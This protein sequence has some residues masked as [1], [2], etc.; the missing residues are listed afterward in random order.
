ML[1]LV[2][3]PVCVRSNT[4]LELAL[5]LLEA[6]LKCASVYLNELSTR[7]LVRGAA[8]TNTYMHGHC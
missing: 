3:Q 7:L 6:E 2:G 1:W 4:A 5:H 8:H